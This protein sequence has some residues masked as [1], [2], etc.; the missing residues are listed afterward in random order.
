MY[1]KVLE[2]SILFIS[3]NLSLRNLCLKTPGLCIFVKIFKYPFMASF[4]YNPLKYPVYVM[5][6]AVG[7]ACNLRCDY[8]YYLEKEMLSPKGNG[9]KMTDATLQA[10]T[11]QY[12]HAQPSQEVLFT[13]HGGEP[14]ILGIDYYKK[15]LRFQQVF[16][17]NRQIENVLQTNGVLLTDDWCKFL[18]DNNFLIGLS[19]DGP[20]QCHDRYRK[21]ANGRG[22]FVETMRGIELLQKHEVDFNVLSVVNDYNAKYPLEVYHF[23]KSIGAQY[24]QFSPVVER[25]DPNSGLLAS[26][27]KAGGVLTP[28]SVSALDY[29]Q[30]LCTIFDE[31]V[32]NDVGKT[33]VTTFDATLAGYVGVAPGVCIYGETCGHAAALEANGDLYACDHFVFPE[34]KRGNIH[35]KTLT[36]MMLSEE[37]IKFGN[38][39]RDKLPQTCRQCTYLHLCNGECPKNRILHIE[40]EDGAFNYLCPGLKIYFNHTE[41]YLKYMANELSNKRPPANIMQA[42]R[43]PNR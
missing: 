5:T 40:G 7:A 23:F 16:K 24:I 1:T 12:V 32:F 18:K 34:Y 19:I 9:F 28:W 21:S 22:S 37:Q 8:C 15:A 33:Y 31:W 13:W 26:G 20:E 29:G 35:R 39:K 30:F 27:M 2:I 42:L 41:P 4:Q 10:F 3:C 6:K 25:M 14:L 17:R 11:E 38:D 36:E 43:N